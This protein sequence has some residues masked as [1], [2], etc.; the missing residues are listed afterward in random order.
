MARRG[1]FPSGLGNRLT[2]T[3]HIPEIFEE[4][5]SHLARSFWRH[6]GPVIKV[7]I[8]PFPVSCQINENHL[9][10]ASYCRHDTVEPSDEVIVVDPV[11]LATK[12]E[13]HYVRS[14]PNLVFDALEMPR[15]LRYKNRLGAKFPRFVDEDA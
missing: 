13:G 10:L 6:V 14:T 5:E 2:G 4:I 8:L 12:Q 1:P 9:L 15:G 7:A 11:D 3:Y